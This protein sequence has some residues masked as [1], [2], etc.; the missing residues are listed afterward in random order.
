MDEHTVRQAFDTWYESAGPGLGEYT[1][2]GRRAH[3]AT[4][5]RPS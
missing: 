5:R 2:Q 1:N 4:S 3:H